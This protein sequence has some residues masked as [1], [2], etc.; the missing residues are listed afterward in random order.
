MDQIVEAQAEL[1]RAKQNLRLAVHE[2][3]A[4]GRTWADIGRTLG[5]T[6]QAAFKRFGQPIHPVTG[7]EI[8][9]ARM[10]VEQVTNLTE[11]VFRLISSGDYAGLEPLLH[12]DVRS[13]LSEDLIMDTWGRVLSE[14]GSL[15][16]QSDTHVVISPD[17]RIEEDEQLLG[18]VVGVTTLNC[19]A[20]E[21]MG[22][23]AVDD[24]LRIVGLL[25]VPT[26]HAP[27]PF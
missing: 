3:R 16:T 17:E 8:T 6:R 11:R 15:E 14:V 1:E 20:G 21:L 12:P 9:G 10:S 4:A 26:D 2:A 25:I 27:L 24:Q 23:V 22:R 18:I 7:H 5:M 19:E 13:E